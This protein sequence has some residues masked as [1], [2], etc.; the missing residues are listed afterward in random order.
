[1][2]HLWFGRQPAQGADTRQCQLLVDA[3]LPWACVVI[4]NTLLLSISRLAKKRGLRHT[5]TPI[6]IVA[7]MAREG[8][9][10]LTAIGFMPW[11][12]TVTCRALT[13]KRGALSGQ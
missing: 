8:L 7:V 1:M 2:A 5:V 13:P 4:A 3:F 6:V 11:V 12:G 9:P 10:Q